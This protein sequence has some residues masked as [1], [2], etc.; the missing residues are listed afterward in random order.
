MSPPAAVR[1]AWGRRPA[2]RRPPPASASRCAARG[3]LLPAGGLPSRVRTC[4]PRW[5]RLACLAG[6]PLPHTGRAFPRPTWCLVLPS[7]LCCTDLTSS[8]PLYL[9]SAS[10]SV[11]S[12]W[13]DPCFVVQHAALAHQSHP[14]SSLRV[15]NKCRPSSASS[16]PRA[17]TFSLHLY[18]AVTM[19]CL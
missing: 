15:A 8:K 12:S 18:C 4:V 7:V 6:L 13:F 10:V 1:Q 14:A 9:A 17:L 11:F 19:P 2:S 3:H 16:S 5:A